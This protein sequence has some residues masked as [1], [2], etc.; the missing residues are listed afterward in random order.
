MWAGSWVP[1]PHLGF[2][3]PAP[4]FEI[5]SASGE[6]GYHFSRQKNE[7][8]ELIQLKTAVQLLEGEQ[9][10]NDRIEWDN[11]SPNPYITRQM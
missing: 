1:L 7:S 8:Q 11:Q 10:R 2:L 6:I 4:F 3:G 5:G 9:L